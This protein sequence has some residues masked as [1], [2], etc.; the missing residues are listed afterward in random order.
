MLRRDLSRLQ[1]SLILKYKR[2]VRVSL[3]Y[4]YLETVV[5]SIYN[6]FT[7]LISHFANQLLIFPI[8]KR[9]LNLITSPLYEIRLILDKKIKRVRRYRKFIYLEPFRILS[10]TVISLLFSISGTTIEGS[11]EIIN[12]RFAFALS[13][14]SLVRR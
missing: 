2:R 4:A 11:I 9:Y 10:S 6:L 5:F 13:L 8:M 12:V 7:T 1:L 14:H 3:E